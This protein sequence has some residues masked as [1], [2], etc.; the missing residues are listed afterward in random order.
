[1][2]LVEF[3]V[4]GYRSLKG[5]RVKLDR[6][7]VI[8]GPNGCGKSNLYRSLQLVHE[9]ARGNLGR[10]IASEGG[11]QS[12]LWAGPRRGGKPVRLEIE[13]LTGD[14]SYCLSLGLPVPRSTP[15]DLDPLVKSET[16]SVRA[17][18]SWAPVLD[19]SPEVCAFRRP[20][21]RKETLGTALDRSESVLSQ[22]QDVDRVPFLFGFR[23]EVRSWRFYHQF[24]TDPESPLRRPQTGTLSPVLDSD[25]RNL[26]AAI[27]TLRWQGNEVDFNEAV[28]DAFPGARILTEG[29]EV[30]EMSLPEFE[31]R[32]FS[33]AEL[34]DG[35]LRYL[36]LAAALLSAR[37]PTLIALNEPE[38]SLH[39]SLLPPLGR[40]IA[41]SSR[42]SQLWVTTH[43][44]IL[45]RA[46]CESVSARV[47]RLYR[48]D[49]ATYVEGA[50][51]LLG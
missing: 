5:L 42:R 19:R 51:A 38:A 40:L 12:V 22:L 2:S 29:G 24:R 33:P 49:G 31:D 17:G 1:M 48:K 44:E 28:A 46:I 6:V 30:C 9:A 34:S 16:L 50:S 35:T 45:A 23:E 7:S 8:V 15:F 41:R 32:L 18:E 4:R 10:C 21:G 36:A 39:E 37:P 11:L 20:D 43:S 3:E 25:G 14:Y 26:A 13:C 47:I 27:E